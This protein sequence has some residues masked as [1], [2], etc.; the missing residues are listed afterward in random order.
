[1]R[2]GLSLC[3]WFS[4]G[5][6]PESR[7]DIP[8]PH[9]DLGSF[10]VPEKTDG[11]AVTHGIRITLDTSVP[12]TPYLSDS[13]GS[14]PRLRPNPDLLVD[15]HQNADQGER[16]QPDLG[17]GRSGVEPF[18]EPLD[19]TNDMENPILQQPIP[20]TPSCRPGSLLVCYG[21]LVGVR[22]MAP[23]TRCHRVSRISRGHLEFFEGTP[24]IDLRNSTTPIL[25]NP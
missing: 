7:L 17:K 3:S 21:R 18:V 25:D 16:I 23:G 5:H 12:D 13:R 10:E 11:S 24:T 20:I 8:T 4:S 6:V 22:A 9:G 1:M 2:T 14:R 19:S 15:G